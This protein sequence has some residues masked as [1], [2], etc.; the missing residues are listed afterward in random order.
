VNGA[1]IGGQTFIAKPLNL[2]SLTKCIE[3]HTA[4]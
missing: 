3:E 1:H 4:S 2:K